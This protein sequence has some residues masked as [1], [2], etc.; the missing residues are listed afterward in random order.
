MCESNPPFFES[1]GVKKF[2][3]PNPAAAEEVFEKIYT[4]QE[5]QL[6]LYLAAVRSGAIQQGGKFPRAL[7]F[8]CGFSRLTNK[9]NGARRMGITKNRHSRFLFFCEGICGKLGHRRLSLHL[10]AACTYRGYRGFFLQY[11]RRTPAAA[12]TGARGRCGKTGPPGVRVFHCGKA[13]GRKK[14]RDGR[15]RNLPD[16]HRVIDGVNCMDATV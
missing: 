16:V 14:S 8:V 4:R 2:V 9:L 7:Q 5:L 6:V 13:A 15:P 11:V 10:F 1:I 12:A 3:L